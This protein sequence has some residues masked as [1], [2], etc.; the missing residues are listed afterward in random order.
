MNTFLQA[1]QKAAQTH[2]WATGMCDEFVAAMYGYPA[3]GYDTALDQWNS[4]P[5]DVE[6][7]GD[8]DAPAGAL[9]FWEE[10]GGG[11][12]GHVALS[13]G[14]GGIYSTDISGDGTVSHVSSGEIASK[15][16][17]SYLG[18]SQPIFEGS[19]AGAVG[20]YQATAAGTATQASVSSDV[21]SVGSSILDFLTGGSG[22]NTGVKDLLERGALILFGAVLVVVALV[23]FSRGS[24]VVDRVTN[25]VKDS[26]KAKEDGL[27]LANR[28][29]EENA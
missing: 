24:G 6:H 12:D 29:V 18:W 5:G 10:K 14:M 26:D 11:G 23:Q 9:M 22:F 17:L 4:M 28:E 21:G 3:S 1:L 7:P 13:D 20:T 15:W 27:K 8:M 25:T 2:T 19:S 16:G